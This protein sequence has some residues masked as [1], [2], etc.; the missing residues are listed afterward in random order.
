MKLAMNASNKYKIF[1]GISSALFRGKVGRE[2]LVFIHEGR[3][4]AVNTLN[5]KGQLTGEIN[6]K[7]DTF[8]FTI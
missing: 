2:H 6:V 7:K 5:Q 3:Y 8:F 1:K 4:R